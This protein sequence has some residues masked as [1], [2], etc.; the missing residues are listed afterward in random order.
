MD[1]DVRASDIDALGY[2]RISHPAITSR[3]AQGAGI[4]FDHKRASSHA[5]FTIDVRFPAL[6]YGARL[7]GL[8]LVAST[9][10]AS[11]QLYS[12]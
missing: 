4:S 9:S 3:N 8:G 12:A 1:P 11:V 5:H 2:A 7:T 10:R 6:L